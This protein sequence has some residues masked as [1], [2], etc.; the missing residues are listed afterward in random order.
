M[1]VREALQRLADRGLRLTQQRRCVVAQIGAQDSHFDAED[2]VSSLA[3]GQERV[4]RA[5]V[6]RLL[7]V[8]VQVGL[9]REVMA[10]G[11]RREYEVV[12][13]SQ[14]HE[15]FVCEHCG[16]VIEFRDQALEDAI[17]AAA[18]KRGLEMRHHSVEIAGIC[19]RCARERSR[20]GEGRS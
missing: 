7:P 1:Q 9:L 17:E 10:F 20:A 13:V 12:E 2:L 4:S 8:L 11:H 18:H 5:T 14:H 16:E 19:P 6:Y 3:A 15:H